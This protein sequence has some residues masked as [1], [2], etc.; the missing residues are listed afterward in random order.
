MGKL[1]L[2]TSPW[3]KVRVGSRS[4]GTTPIVGASLPAG[5]HTIHLED[6]R[7]RRF[8]RKVQ[9]RAGVPTKAFFDLN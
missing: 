2:H 8:T 1:Y 6:A 3:S 4:L 7:G 9:I 5:T